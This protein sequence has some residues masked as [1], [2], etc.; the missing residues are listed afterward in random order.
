MTMILASIIIQ[1]NQTFSLVWGLKLYYQFEFHMPTIWHVWRRSCATGHPIGQSMA[2]LALFI[3]GNTQTF[4]LE[5][6]NQVYCVHYS[7]NP[8]PLRL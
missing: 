1:E 2:M 4:T 7:P 8:K 6:E 5:I 3:S